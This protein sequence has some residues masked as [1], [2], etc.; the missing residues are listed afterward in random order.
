MKLTMYAN[1]KTEGVGVE[2]PADVAVTLHATDNYGGIGFH[3]VSPAQLHDI[4]GC[5]Q[6]N[7]YSLLVEA[8]RGHRHDRII[9]IGD[10]PEDEDEDAPCPICDALAALDAG[11][12]PIEVAR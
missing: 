1:Y 8:A 9:E 12:K 10:P 7:T 6:A 2:L 5:P 4:I 11:R 3:N